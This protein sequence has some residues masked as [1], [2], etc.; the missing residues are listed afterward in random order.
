MLQEIPIVWK[1][2]RND[3]Y[4]AMLG[5]HQLAYVLRH[6]NEAVWRWVISDCNGLECY[7][8]RSAR[9]LADAKAAVKDS[10]HQ[11]FRAAGLLHLDS[12]PERQ[13]V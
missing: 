3:A 2:I 12:V 7:E 10:V 9:S 8:F 11:W 4:A 5:E 13:D 1:S 6:E